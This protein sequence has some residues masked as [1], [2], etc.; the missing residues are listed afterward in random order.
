MELANLTKLAER[1]APESCL[2]LLH[3]HWDNKIMPSFFYIGSG[4]EI[5]PQLPSS[6]VLLIMAKYI[7]YGL[8]LI[9]W[10]H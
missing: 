2:S 7:E 5:T 8:C 4:I 10:W 6:L 1:Q 9:V 3:Q